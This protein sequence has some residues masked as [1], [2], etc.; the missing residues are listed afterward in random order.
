MAAGVVVTTML[1]VMMM[2]V[3]IVRMVMTVAVIMI[4]RRMTVRMVMRFVRRVRVTLGRIGATL[5]IERRFDLDHSRAQTLDHCVDDVVAPDSQRLSHDLRR[6]MAITKMPA[7][8][9]QM[10]RI[11]TADLQKRLCRGHDLDQ[12]AIV[13]HQCITAA[14]CDRILEIEQEFQ[15]TRARHRHPPPVTVVE[16]KH[17]RIGRRLA[18]AMLRLDLRCAEHS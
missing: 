4:V 14:Q 18:P 6:Q 11:V 2:V 10:L 15:P 13:E 3:V 12:P 1:V 9:H 5:W 16:V 7:E 17:D 8:P